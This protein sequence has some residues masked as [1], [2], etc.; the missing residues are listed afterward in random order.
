VVDAVAADEP[1]ALAVLVRENALAVDLLLEDPAFAMEGLA[2]EGGRHGGVLWDQRTDC[3]VSVKPAD[4]GGIGG[5]DIMYLTLT[6]ASRYRDSR[7]F[8]PL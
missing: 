5:A 3:P 6:Y 2:D 4:C 7:S 8:G 1:D